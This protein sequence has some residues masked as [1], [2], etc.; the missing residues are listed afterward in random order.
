MLTVQKY[1]MSTMRFARVF[2]STAPKS[3]YYKKGLYLVPIVAKTIREDGDTQFIDVECDDNKS[4]LIPLIPK[5]TIQRMDAIIFSCRFVWWKGNMRSMLDKSSRR[6]I[7]TN[8][9]TNRRRTVGNTNQSLSSEMVL[10]TPVPLLLVLVLLAKL[11]LHRFSMEELLRSSF[12]LSCM[13]VIVI[14]IKQMDI[15]NIKVCNYCFP[16]LFLEM[17]KS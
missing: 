8:Y 6:Y 4:L 1:C 11:N 17:Y 7:Q 16:A 10:T 12:L 2:A 5:T 13:F 14:S 9:T 3:D 15:I